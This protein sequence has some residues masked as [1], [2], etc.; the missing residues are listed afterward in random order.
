L[1]HNMDLIITKQFDIFQPKCQIN[2]INCKI[3]SNMAQ[4][5]VCKS[6]VHLRDTT[7]CV[8]ILCAP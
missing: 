3:L 5:Y 8:Q 6:C 4:L 2:W 7:V 1:A